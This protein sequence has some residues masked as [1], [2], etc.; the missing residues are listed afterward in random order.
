[1]TARL[2]YAVQVTDP[3]SHHVGVTLTVPDAPELL[4]LHVPRW[5]PGSYLLREH[6]RHVT[7]V[8]ATCRGQPAVVRKGSPHHW[9]V[10]S[11]GGEVQVSYRAYAHELTVRT[12]H[13]D[14]SHAFLNLVCLL[15]VPPGD[16]ERPCALSLSPPAG[17]RVTTSLKEVGPLWY[18]AG[19]YHDL[20]DAPVEMGTHRVLPFT[21]RGVPHELC[22]WGRGNEDEGRLLADLPRL[23]EQNASLFGGLPYDRYLFITLLT[24]G[25]RGGLEHR[26]STALC[27]P[28]F[29]FRA[30]KEYESFLTL[31]THEHFHAWNVKRIRP[32]SFQSYDY[33]REVPTRELWA[34]EGLTSYYDNLHTRRAGL[35]SP[36]RYLAVL[37]E[38]TT[39]LWQTP[40]RREHALE[41]ASLDAWVKYYR[42]DEN[43]AHS[44]VSYYV[45]G[46]LVGL[47]LDLTLRD[48]TRG[49]GSLDDVM[50]LVWRWTRERGEGLEEGVFEAAAAEVAGRSMKPF[51]DLAVRSTR[52]LP[53]AE[54]LAT[55]GLELRGRSPESL[56]DRGGA[57]G[58]PRH[59]PRAHLGATIRRDGL[60]QVVQPGGPAMLAG[61]SPGDQLVALAGWRIT[62]GTLGARLEELR[63]G[64]PA[65]VH[66]FRRD[67]LRS[68]TLTLE[69]A[70]AT[71]A[72][73]RRMS[74]VPDLVVAAR[75]AWLGAE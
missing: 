26:D 11:P 30:E 47:C 37:G 69:P 44:T 28:R 54:C 22:L 10:R 68:A 18:V 2:S 59:E 40:G 33:A 8:V 5:T 36:D 19:S 72:Y 9:E 23:V 39:T 73:I 7:S 63:P 13:V 64:A 57:P 27:H 45:K 29:G 35:M 61:L 67:E 60:V 12:S 62:D 75:K 71:C 55:V 32:R 17:W 48:V 3:R 42:P 46:E 74:G 51:F 58:R 43:S 50:R 20:V 65:T 21:V 1:M 49:Q 66:F 14:D 34:Y 4:K 52:E 15:M 38:I 53:L 6:G 56:E 16:E 70:P 25:G 24:D 31:C 41:D